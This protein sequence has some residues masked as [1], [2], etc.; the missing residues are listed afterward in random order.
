MYVC[1]L[2]VVS[3]NTNHYNNVDNVYKIMIVL[4]LFLGAKRPLST[5]YFVRP[6]KIHKSINFGQPHFKIYLSLSTLSC[7]A[8]E[9]IL[10]K[11]VFLLQFFISSMQ[12]YSRNYVFRYVFWCALFIHFKVSYAMYILY[13]YI[14]DISFLYYPS[15]KLIYSSMCMYWYYWKCNYPMNPH[16]CLYRS[17]HSL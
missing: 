4:G 8:I 5:D 16:D 7:V 17:T 14:V 15:L 6:S 3:N 9:I 13:V 12:Q 11:P 2:L 1:Y 10:A